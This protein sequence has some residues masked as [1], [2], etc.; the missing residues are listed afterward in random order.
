MQRCFL[1]DKKMKEMNMFSAAR[2]RAD[3]DIRSGA[4]SGAGILDRLAGD[5]PVD[6]LETLDGWYK[7]K[8]TRL[9]HGISGYLPE[10]ALTFPAEVSPPVFPVIPLTA[11]GLNVTPSVTHSVKV[12]AFLQWLAGAGKPGWL[13]EIVLSKLSE[14]QQAELFKKMRVASVGNQPHWDDWMADLKKNL[15]LEDAVMDEWIVMMKGGREVYA[16]RDHYIYINPLQDAGYYGCALKGQI[17]R[18]TGIV[19]SSEK[20]GKRTNFYEVDFYRMSRYMH[21]WF[22]ADIAAEYI[23]P[24]PDNDYTVDSNALKVFDLT[25]AVVR[26]PQDQAITDTKTKGYSAAQYID[27]YG[28][29]GRHLVHFSLCGE[30]CVAA[31]SGKDV[32]PLLKSWLDSKFYRAPSILKDPH[33]GTSAADL[34]SLLTVVGLQ[35]ELYTSIPTTPQIIKERLD[36]GQFAIVGCGINSGGKIKADGKIRHWVVLEDILPVGNNGWVR[37][38]NPFNNRDEVYTYSLFIASA[39]VGA[40]LWITPKPQVQV[41]KP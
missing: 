8:P 11:D 24:T 12:S 15:R 32:L 14:M 7:V 36:S 2:T 22:R 29:T 6:I 39:G 41:P 25:M 27:V 33:E 1:F 30:F 16:I 21:G 5:C 35:G 28:A 40:G 4:K 3:V 26:M 20:N 10:A 23:F 18:W 38:Y 34:Q 37:V 13:S 19:R 31:L 9:V 17:M